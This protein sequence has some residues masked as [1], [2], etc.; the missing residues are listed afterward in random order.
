[1]SFQQMCAGAMFAVALGVAACGSN[2]D[3]SGVAAPEGDTSGELAAESEASEST[4]SVAATESSAS[5]VS[6]SESDDGEVD[7]VSDSPPVDDPDRSPPTTETSGLAGDGQAPAEPEG[8]TCWRVEDFGEEAAGRWRV[9]N[10][11][12]MGGLSQGEL[13]FNGGVATFAGTINTNG[14][15]FSMIRTSI[16]RDGATL[17]DS[18]EGAEYL[19]VRTR[20]ANGRAYELTVQDTA[21]NSAVMHF[22]DL[23]V[24]AD[25]AWEEP[26]VPLTD[27]DARTFG[28]ARPNLADFDLDQISTFGIILADGID[29]PFSLAIDRIDACS[30]P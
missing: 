24:T 15:G 4:T 20:S 27:L 14:G 1:M 9:I 30:R 12:V 13:T 29:G 23:A 7:A 8:L 3:P 21:S 25:S 2:V 22:T 11:G 19:R 6:E 28:T 17:A 16:F 26:L 5:S 18:L 10:D